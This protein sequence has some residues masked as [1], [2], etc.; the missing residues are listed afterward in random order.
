[1]WVWF[2]AWGTGKHEAGIWIRTAGRGDG[3]REALGS[4]TVSW[5]GCFVDSCLRG[6][7]DL[8]VSYFFLTGVSS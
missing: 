8:V 4:I 3:A 1:M 5:A 7:I 2:R 6:T